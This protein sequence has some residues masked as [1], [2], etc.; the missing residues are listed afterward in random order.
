MYEEL[1]TFKVC[2]CEKGIAKTACPSR[3]SEKRKHS[4]TSTLRPV[5]AM[6]DADR[7]DIWRGTEGVQSSA[8]P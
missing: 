6:L 8:I 7:D 5:T 3:F 4:N 2:A 1:T